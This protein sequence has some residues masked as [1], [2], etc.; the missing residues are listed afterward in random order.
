MQS[1][2]YDF[3]SRAY[4]WL[5][6]IDGSQQKSICFANSRSQAH[7]TPYDAVWQRMILNDAAWFWMTPYDAVL[8]CIT[9]NDAVWYWTTPYDAV[10]GCITPNDAEWRCFLSFDVRWH[11]LTRIESTSHQRA[12]WRSPTM[13]YMA[14]HLAF[15]FLF[16]SFRKC[17]APGKLFSF[18]KRS[19]C[20]QYAL[21]IP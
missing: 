13:A 7:M 12:R 3:R 15:F 19:N 20:T 5:F 14:G 21:S 1:W 11:W 8:G 10:W 18:F 16:K 6:I 4:G 17:P 9:L 2:F